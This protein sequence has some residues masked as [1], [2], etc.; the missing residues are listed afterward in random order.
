MT[1]N[2]LKATGAQASVAIQLTEL[3]FYWPNATIPTLAIESLIVHKG[4]QIFISGPSGSGKS[5]LLGLI[6]GILSPTS[7]SI[8][9]ND[10]L[11]NQLSGSERDIFRGDHIGFIFQQFNLI[12]YLTVL[13]NVLIPCQ[14][15]R[16]RAAQSIQHYGSIVDEAKALLERLDLSSKLWHQKANQLSVGQQQRVAAARAL[17]GKPSILIADEPTSALDADR[18]QDFLD[19]LLNACREHDI[20]LLFVSH[21]RE[22]MSSFERVIHLN[23]IN[24]CEKGSE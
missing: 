19:L 20:T 21:D 12:P 1:I 13:E 7:G 2:D 18:R 24:V 5:T 11:T 14:L 9:I 10:C 15:S 4:E 23:D 6:A 3:D 22:I 8:I 17:M 16:L